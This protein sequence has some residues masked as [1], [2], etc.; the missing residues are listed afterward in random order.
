[1]MRPAPKGWCPTAEQPM[2]SGDGLIVRL[3]PR[4]G[5]LTSEAVFSILELSER[6]GN[7]MIDVT[8]RANLQLRGVSDKNHT[9]IL[10]ALY[11]LALIDPEQEAQ[12][13]RNL[14]LAPNWDH[15]SLGEKLAG[16]FY[17]RL[18][19]LPP[20]PSKFGFSIDMEG[21]RS[22][23][24]VSADIRLEILD[25]KTVLIYADGT[26]AGRTVSREN[27]V[28]AMHKLAEWFVQTGGRQAGRMA[29][30]LLEQPL[31]KDWQEVPRSVRHNAPLP[32]G[33][34]DLGFVVGIPFGQSSASAL[35]DLMNDS[36]ATAIRL[37]PW[38]SLLLEG[39]KAVQTKG[40]IL[41]PQQ[42][43][44]QANACSG[45]PACQAASVETRK[46]AQ[47]LSAKTT[48]SLHVSGCAKGCAFPKTAE[49]TVTG[50][51][52]RY[53]LILN[54]APWDV[55]HTSALTQIQLIKEIERL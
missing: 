24:N 10:S 12:P 42:H 6:F 35:R 32:P 11:D 37:T 34:N 46:V 52:G 30:H 29:R 38:R 15:G 20:L 27:A 2:A 41:S 39:A 54:G 53:D 9:E 44:G 36:A 49:I 47:I 22:L 33:Q 51:D 7:T 40:F 48:K 25:A 4:Y 17:D 31:P 8:N 3:R 50:R 5:R 14:T 28:S 18:A 16:E 45:A 55:P 13:G 43:L 21:Q 19:E 1:M 23:Q 26:T